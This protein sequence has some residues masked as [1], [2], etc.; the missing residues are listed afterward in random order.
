MHSIPAM[1]WVDS[2]LDPELIKQVRDYHAIN[3]PVVY[4]LIKRYP[5]KRAFVFSTRTEAD[6]WLTRSSRD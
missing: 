6:A 3:H 2:T 4:A 5:Q 1:P